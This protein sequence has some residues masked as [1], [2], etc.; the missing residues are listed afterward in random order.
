MLDS[1][2]TAV[3]LQAHLCVIMFNTVPEEEPAAAGSVSL[4]SITVVTPVTFVFF[5]QSNSTEK[6]IMYKIFFIYNGH[7]LSTNV[8]IAIHPVNKCFSNFL[9]VMAL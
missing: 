2:L 8:Q 1:Y 6:L 9:I 7:S 5:S 4:H 3:S